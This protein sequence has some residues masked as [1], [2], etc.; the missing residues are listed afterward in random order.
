VFCWND[1]F[2]TQLWKIVFFCYLWLKPPTS[3]LLCTFQIENLLV[4][5]RQGLAA[6]EMNGN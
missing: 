1:G 6:V 5:E 4:F 2:T 3:N